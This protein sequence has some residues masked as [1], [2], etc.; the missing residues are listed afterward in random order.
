MRKKRKQKSAAKLSAGQQNARKPSKK[1][2]KIRIKEQKLKTSA[3][4]CEVTFRLPKKAVPGAQEVSIVGDFNNWNITETPMKKHKNGDF[5]LT[6]ELPCNREYRFRYL[7]NASSW[8]NDSFAD[9]YIPGSYVCDD[10]VAVLQTCTTRQSSR[11]P[12][13]K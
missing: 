11:R 6:L 9:K 13:S 3:P 1:T 10:S 8:E 2:G 4:K 7:I 5:A 12:R